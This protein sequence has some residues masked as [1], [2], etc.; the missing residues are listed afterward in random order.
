MMYTDSDIVSLFLDMFVCISK[1]YEGAATCFYRAHL[2]RAR[3]LYSINILFLENLLILLFEKE[4]ATQCSK[5][6]LDDPLVID[7]ADAYLAEGTTGAKVELQE[8]HD[9]AG[10]RGTKN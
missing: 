10:E 5:L 8:Y 1:N 6:I 2:M 7:A 4:A 9:G 3:V